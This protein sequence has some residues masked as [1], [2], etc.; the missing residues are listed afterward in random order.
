MAK[1]QGGGKKGMWGKI[2]DQIDVPS[3]DRGDPN[4]DSEREVYY[5]NVY[6]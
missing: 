4:F 2:E 3:V 1:K 5:N 6:E